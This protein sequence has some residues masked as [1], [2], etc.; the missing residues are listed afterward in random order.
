MSVHLAAHDPFRMEETHAHALVTITFGGLWAVRH[1]AANLCR[2]F[3]LETFFPSGDG[4]K[5]VRV[6]LTVDK[7]TGRILNRTSL[8]STAVN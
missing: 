1:C 6:M 8:T 4:G 2:G 5:T 7:P 3:G